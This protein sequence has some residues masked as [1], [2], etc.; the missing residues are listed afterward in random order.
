M[1][2][3][4]LELVVMVM[5]LVFLSAGVVHMLENYLKMGTLDCAYVYDDGTGPEPSCA[6]ESYTF[7]DASC[8][9]QQNSCHVAYLHTDKDGEPSAIMCDL[10]PFFDCFYFIVITMSTVGYGDIS[11]TTTYSKFVVIF[12]VII[13][14]TTVPGQLADIARLISMGSEFRAPYAVSTFDTHVIIGGHVNDK[15]KLDSFLTQFFT[16][17]KVMSNSAEVH[18]VVVFE[19]L[20]KAEVKELLIVYENRV[21]FIH[22]SMLFADDLRSNCTP[23]PLLSAGSSL[24]LHSSRCISL[25]S[26]PLP[27]PPLLPPP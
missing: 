7:S 11:P 4:I 14:V 19:E 20:P 16:A 10:L 12:F 26:L 24:C 18:V 3:E 13:L 1:A 5:S 15:F 23:Y 22:G 25:T 2:R 21:H 27:L 6:K 17:N 8:D 9:C